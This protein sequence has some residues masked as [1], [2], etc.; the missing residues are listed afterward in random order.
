MTPAR[1]Q[2]LQQL[3]VLVGS[4]RTGGNDPLGTL[5]ARVVS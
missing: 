2:T 3:T 5:V 1:Q 4:M